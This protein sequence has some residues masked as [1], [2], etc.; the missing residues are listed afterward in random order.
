MALIHVATSLEQV[1]SLRDPVQQLLR[2]EQLDA[3]GG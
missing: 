3:R 2:A 1:Q